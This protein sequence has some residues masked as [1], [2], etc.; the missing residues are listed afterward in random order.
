[1]N[2]ASKA[3][4]VDAIRAGVGRVQSTFGELT[5][6]QLDTQVYDGPTGWTARQV[7]AHLAGR[8]D[9]YDLLI[10]LAEETGGAPPGGFD[11]D[12][13]NQQLIVDRQSRSL[14]TLLREFQQVHERLIARVEAL[15]DDQLQRVVVFPN[16][17]TTL[18]DVLLGS[19]GMHSIQHAEDVEKSLGLPG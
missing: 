8:E 9:T 13:W 3:E 4:I 11:I 2:L 10:Q 18:G 7:L 14:G 12:T 17:E 19:G 6:E 16:Q 15:R 1:M 5:E